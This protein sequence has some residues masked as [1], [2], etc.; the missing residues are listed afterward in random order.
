MEGG[1]LLMDVYNTNGVN[2]HCCTK[3]NKIKCRIGTDTERSETSRK[4]S[5]IHILTLHDTS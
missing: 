2:T 3:K 4:K 5:T 1:D